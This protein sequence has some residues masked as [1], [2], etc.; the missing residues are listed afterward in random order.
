MNGQY[1]EFRKIQGQQ[2]QGQPGFHADNVVVP[3]T[4]FERNR[5]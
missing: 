2:H 3:G 4:G 5:A 1:G